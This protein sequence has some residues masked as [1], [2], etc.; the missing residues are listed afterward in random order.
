MVRGGDG[1][2]VPAV[3]G[4]VSPNRMET[5]PPVRGN[6]P[7]RMEGNQTSGNLA[8][9][10]HLNVLRDLGARTGEELIEVSR[11]GTPFEAFENA[12]EMARVRANLGDDAVP[13]LQ[14]IGE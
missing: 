12:R 9:N 6:E 4:G 13:F 2:L 7:L 3:A 14:E 10:T 1:E 8:R 5:E 11:G